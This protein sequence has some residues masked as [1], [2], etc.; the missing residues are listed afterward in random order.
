LLNGTTDDPA[1]IKSYAD[2]LDGTPLTT[3]RLTATPSELTARARARACSEMALLAGDDIAGATEEYLQQILD[4]ALRAQE[5][6]SPANDLV[7]DTT[8]L[9]GADSAR[10]VLDLSGI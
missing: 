7:L 10:M 1:Q 6:W 2:H 4:D 9:S 5:S 3:V 8:S